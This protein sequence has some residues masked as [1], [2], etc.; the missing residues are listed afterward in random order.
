MPG[1]DHPGMPRGKRGWTR[2][3]ELFLQTG[4]RFA[5][6]SGEALCAALRRPV[7]KNLGRAL[8]LALLL[9]PFAVLQLLN[10]LCLALDHLL[11]P[12][13]RH[14]RVVDP[15]FIVGVPRSGTTLLHRIM[16]E[17]R[18]CTTFTAWECLFAPSIVQ[19]AAV[20]AAGRVDRLLGR[21][22]GRLLGWLE[23]C[24]AGRLAT[25]HP[26][27]LNAPEEDFLA[28]LPVLGCFLLVVPFPE[29]RWVWS[30]G[31]FDEALPENVRV[32]LMS[33]YKGLVQRHLYVHGPRL[34]FLSKNPSFSPMV[35]SLRQTF[36]SCRIVACLRD[37]MQTVPSQLSALKPAMAVFGHDPG[38]A[39]VRDRLVSQM[40]Y[41]YDYLL[42]ELPGG[43][44]CRHAFVMLPDLKK[45]T[46]GTVQALYRRLG[47]PFPVKFA[48]CLDRLED[49]A[50]RHQSGHRYSAEGFGLSEGDIRGRFA[51]AYRFLRA[52]PGMTSGVR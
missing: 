7:G 21:P 9:P 26:S 25:I 30:L 45:A 43:P 27:G 17:D 28:L 37:P 49:A 8:L 36:P 39:P 34:R 52:S 16:A 24:V 11:F 13:F 35:R 23:R 19:R 12:G 46:R 22:A 4:I 32:Q 51:S 31:R 29:S 1:G 15:V 50:R 2:V 10:W 40:A 41:Y 18:A 38:A 33:F 5:G 20:R 3:F 6:L 47:L 48:A 42:T 44:V 14:V